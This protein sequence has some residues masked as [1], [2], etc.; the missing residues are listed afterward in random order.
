VLLSIRFAGVALA[1]LTFA[2]TTAS[3]QTSSIRI[4]AAEA[5][6]RQSADPQS[7]AI[8]T[9]KAGT[10]LEI[11]AERN[12]WYEVILPATG[13]AAQRRGYVP[14]SS[15]ERFNEPRPNLDLSPAAAASAP[16]AADW[17]GRHDRAVG[18]RR[19][20]VTMFWIGGITALTGGAINIYGFIRQATM[21]D[22]ERE[23]ESFWDL[24]GPALA[25]VGGGVA[26]TAVGSRKMRRAAEEMLLL[27]QERTRAQKG[28]VYSHPLI[29]GKLQTA[30]D[31]EAGRQMSATIRMSW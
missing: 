21:T 1:F 5:V 13:G 16:L 31:L 3:A 10:V 17:Q 29:D 30:L 4:T 24:Q 9:V 18:R 2:F 15:A 28:V 22:E 8:V 19:S 23:A 20:G 26:L 6:V 7:A 11:A 25:L 27:E 12:G 14:A